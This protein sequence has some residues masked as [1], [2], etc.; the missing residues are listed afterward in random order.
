MIDTKQLRCR[1]CGEYM[2][3]TPRGNGVCANRSSKLFQVTKDNAVAGRRIMRAKYGGMHRLT[4][5]PIR[6]QFV[7]S[8]TNDEVEVQEATTS[9]AKA[10]AWE[11]SGERVACRIAPD[12]VD[13]VRC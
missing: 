2:D 5:H 11:K 13:F 4:W 10:H 7:A 1:C 6:K 12:R 3:I 8:W 9:W